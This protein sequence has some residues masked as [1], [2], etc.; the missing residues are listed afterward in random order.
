MLRKL[1]V[2][3]A[4]VLL[5][6]FVATVQAQ[7]VGVRPLVVDLNLRPGDT[8]SFELILSPSER[9]EIVNLTLYKPT[10]LITGGLTY[11]LGDPALFAPIGWVE[12]EENRVVVPPNETAKVT[13]RVSVP[14]DAG[15]SYTIVVMVEPE[16]DEAVT[17]ITFRVRY[18]VRI[19]IVVERPGL[20]PRAEIVNFDLASSEEGKP[21]ISAHFRNPS[22]LHYPVSAEVTVRDTNRRLIERVT[23]KTQSAWQSGQETTRIYPGAEVMLLGEV[24]EPLF[25]G[26]YEMRLF[27]RYADLQVIQTKPVT[28]TEGQFA[29]T[30]RMAVV[31]VTPDEI[32]SSLRPGGAAS[33][34]LQIE[35]RLSEFLKVVISGREVVAEYANSVFGNLEIQMRGDQEFQL[36]SRRVNRTV[37]TLRAPRGVTPGGYYGYIDVH[38]YTLTDEYLDTY[39]VPLS[40]IVGDGWD[41][42]AE[43]MSLHALADGNEYLVSV[44]VKNDS[45]AHIIPTGTVYVRDQAGVIVRTLPLTLQEGMENI[46]PQHT[47]FMLS[48]VRDLEPG[49]YTA[50]V[51]IRYLNEEIAVAQ[52]PMV[53]GN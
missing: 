40:L 28:V 11:E 3:V 41:Y 23:L 6:S 44:T 20:R 50:D 22:P 4:L 24:T 32:A 10:Q 37:L 36:E 15:G 12:L 9:Q 30:A 17:G 21:V 46:L 7:A 27:V 29:A 51:R 8:G 26:D 48:T 18:A 34:V 35:N 19:N 16:V 31:R 49:E 53:I 52:L 14:F 25:A 42:Q 5:V 43:V 13:G 33:E 45:V 39:T 47:G 1:T 38:A 2:L